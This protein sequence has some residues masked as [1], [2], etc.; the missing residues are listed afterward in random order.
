MGQIIIVQAFVVF[1]EIIP[2]GGKAEQ[3]HYVV[4]F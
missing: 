3:K 2:A 1:E 4:E